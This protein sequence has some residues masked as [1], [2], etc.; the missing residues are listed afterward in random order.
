MVF[1]NYDYRLVYLLLT[2]PQLFAWATDALSLPTGR[3]SMAGVTVLAILLVLFTGAVSEHVLLLDQ[4]VSWG[5]AGLLL[6]LLAAAVPRF[7]PVPHWRRTAWLAHER[8][9]TTLRQ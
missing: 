9:S 3:S 5:V 8:P 4:L 2:L 1:K 7:W 6:A